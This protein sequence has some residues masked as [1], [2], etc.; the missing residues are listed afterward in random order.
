MPLT[1]SDVM[2]RL[3]L[4]P[5]SEIRDEARTRATLEEG[6]NYPRSWEATFR[7]SGR[8]WRMLVAAVVAASQGKVVVINSYSPHYSRDLRIQARK[9]CEECGI[10]CQLIWL[11]PPGVRL[12]DL[13]LQDHFEGRR[14]F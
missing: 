9:W 13:Y 10:D 4:R 5:W 1:E 14:P 11:G 2:G 6:I 12:P 8:T 7:R 3:G